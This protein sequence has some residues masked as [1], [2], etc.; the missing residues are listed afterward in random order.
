MLF[1]ITNNNNHAFVL[2]VCVDLSI[3]SLSARLGVEWGYNSREDF[4][5]VEIYR[6]NESQPARQPGVHYPR[7]MRELVTLVVYYLSL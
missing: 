7:M 5:C 3:L 6:V 1:W 4:P 2:V